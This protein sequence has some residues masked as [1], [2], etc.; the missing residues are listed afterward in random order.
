MVYQS[1]GANLA[2][3]WRAW[4]VSSAFTLNGKRMHLAL[5][6]TLVACLILSLPLCVRGGDPFE[7]ARGKV[8]LGATLAQC[9]SAIKYRELRPAQAVELLNRHP[10]VETHCYLLAPLK[11][12]RVVVWTD[13][14][15]ACL[16][17]PMYV[18]ATFSEDGKMI[19]LVG[20]HFGYTDPLVRGTYAT[21]VASLK[22][23]M[24]V[25]KMYELVGRQNP[26]YRKKDGKWIVEFT[27]NGYPG[28]F[29]YVEADAATGIIT[30]AR[31]G[32][33]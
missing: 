3:R 18:F 12:G 27:Y 20:S 4:L 15:E 32:T 11:A 22:K 29:Y 26:T 19:D 33:I 7:G 23:G 16:G 8:E 14:K 2:P 10:W 5:P 25:T 30:L 31:N 1:A 24:S 21:R 17:W 13:D 6:R 28:Q 9:R